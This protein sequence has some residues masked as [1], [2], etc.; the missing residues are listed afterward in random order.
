MV[1]KTCDYCAIPVR[2]SASIYTAASF[3]LVDDVVHD[4]VVFALLRV[5]DEIALYVLLYLLQFLAGVLGHDV[6][7]DLAHAQ[8]LAGVNVDV[9]SLSRNSAAHD[10]RLVNEDS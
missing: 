6:V 7:H 9:G 4:S 2:N 3:V 1:M 10:V 5:H 8:N